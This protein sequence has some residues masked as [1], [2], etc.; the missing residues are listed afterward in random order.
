MLQFDLCF[1]STAVPALN[2]VLTWNGTAWTPT[3]SGGGGSAITGLTGDVTA[4]GPGSV[5][6]TV[7]RIQ[8]YAVQNVAPSDGQTLVWS[9]TNTQWEPTT[10]TRELQF[11]FDAAATGASPLVI[12]SVY[13]S[14]GTTIG[15]ASRAMIG[16]SLAGETALLELRRF[17]GGAL[18]AQFAPGAG[19]L[20]DVPVSG[21]PVSVTTSDWYDLYLSETGGGTALAKG[22]QLV[23]S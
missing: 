1:Y 23:L 9:A 19:T 18:L 13:L 15:A 2:D 16:G 7:A 5:P 3:A 11:A 8:G 22:L 20:Q 12:G 14:S 21:G 10:P 4:S 17:T 6:A